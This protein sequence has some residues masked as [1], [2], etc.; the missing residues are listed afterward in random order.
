M[1][2]KR[3]LMNQD[4][5]EH[6]YVTGD[7]SLLIEEINNLAY[8]HPSTKMNDLEKAICVS[9]HSRALIRLGEVKEAENIVNSIPN[10]NFNESF[11]ISSLVYQTSIINLQIT[12]GNITEAL[13]NGTKAETPVEQKGLELSEQPKILSFWGAFFYFLIGMAY[14]HQFSKDLAGKYFQKSLEVNQTNLF[15][16]AKCLYYMSF[17]EQEKDNT[18]E[19]LELLKESMEIFQS[20]DAQQ[21]MAWIFAWQGRFLLQ[22]GDYIK[23]QNKFSQALT[24]FRSISD[25]QGSSLVNSL[26]GLIFYQQGKLEQAE[27]ILEQAFDKSIKIGNPLIL[28]YCFLPL[29]FL[30]IESKNRSKA[31]ECI[32]EFQELSKTTSNDVVKLHGSLAEAIFLKSSSRF[33]DKGQ[34]QLKFLKLLEDS[35]NE[36]FPQNWW[37]L[38]TSDKDFS[39][40]VVYHLI[41]LYI[42]EFKLT[43]DKKIML[44]AQQLIDNHIYKVHDQEFSPELVELSLLKA[45]MVIVDGEIEKALEILEQAKQDANTNNFH[46]LEEK[47]DFEI[48]Q[49]EREFQKWDAAISVRD[50]IEKVQLEDYLK[51]AQQMISSHRVQVKLNLENS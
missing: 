39:F 23:A 2:I 31:Q 20:I 3:L 25:T 17:L 50:R 45:K 42:E 44:E 26:I 5:L 35:Y 4:T 46:R 1:S 13:K 14:Y 10:I 51:E 16:K 8:N 36:K 18:T 43:E 11:S 21:G 48:T 24:L 40:L 28:S 33:I 37:A 30:Y 19:Q 29:V 47:V 32:H 12:Q 38:P 9:Y 34:A 27:E 22:K 49:I 6:L 7:Y 15:I 41:E